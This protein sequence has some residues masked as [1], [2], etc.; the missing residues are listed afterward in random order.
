[1]R[2]SPGT[3]ALASFLVC[4]LE[5]DAFASHTFVV[6][7][8]TRHL[9][10]QMGTVYT[11]NSGARTVSAF[12]TSAWIYLCFTSERAFVHPGNMHW[13]VNMWKTAR[14]KTEYR[15]ETWPQEVSLRYILCLPLDLNPVWCFSHQVY[16]W[17]GS[18]VTEGL[19]I[20][21]IF[22]WC[23]FFYFLH[24]SIFTYSITYILFYMLALFY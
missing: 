5:R 18:P 17:S 12:S 21:L 14:L 11:W 16:F 20:T 8:T 1:M 19:H 3:V 7:S 9:V 15:H 4:F 13:A 24:S 23:F 10:Q 6:Q 22:M 2:N